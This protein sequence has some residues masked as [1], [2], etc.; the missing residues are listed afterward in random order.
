MLYL[1]RNVRFNELYKCGI[2]GELIGPGDYYYEDDEDGLIVKATVY[3]RLEKEK[4][5][6]EFDYTLLNNATSQEEYRQM[7]I[8]ATREFNNQG[9]FDRKIAGRG[10]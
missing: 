2:S 10:E 7:L 6:K 4:K 5:E 1:K 3:R 9:L 8:Q